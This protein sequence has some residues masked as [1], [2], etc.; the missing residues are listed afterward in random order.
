MTDQQDP[1]IQAW[2]FAQH[3]EP[4]VTRPFLSIKRKGGRKI[5]ARDRDRTCDHHHVKVM[6]YR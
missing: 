1:E 5:G 3:P 6:L 2:R 4:E